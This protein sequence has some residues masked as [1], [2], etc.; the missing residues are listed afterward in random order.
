MN[1][2]SPKSSFA[3][4]MPLVDLPAMGD[5]ASGRRWRLRDADAGAAAALAGALQ[6]DPVL[7]RILASR[8][9]AADAAEAYLRPSLREALPDPFVM[10]DMERAAARLAR[11][12]RGGE[13]IGVFGDYDVDGTTA[14]AML[15]IYFDAV[16]A[17]SLTYLPD[18]IAE[19]Y[20]PTA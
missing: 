20:G 5:S 12:V 7:A 9:V 2:G 6:L 18:R 1:A 11:A 15:K 3:A 19:G 13:T 14:S 8:G 10:Q 17:A 16:G 4:A